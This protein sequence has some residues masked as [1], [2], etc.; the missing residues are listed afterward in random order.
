MPQK[1]TLVF[2]LLF[3]V[4]LQLSLYA[5]QLG[6]TANRQN[7]SEG[8]DI[9]DQLAL[10][11]K[12]QT[13]GVVYASPIADQD[14]IYIGSCDSNLYAL[15]K[16]TGA[17]VWRFRSKGEIR[18]SVAIAA[19]L[20]LFMSTDGVFHAIDAA[21]G[22]ERWSFQTKGERFLIPGIIINLHLRCMTVRCML[23]RGINIFMH[24][25]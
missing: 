18:S 14:F 23:V 24:S 10:Q 3:V 12:F 15:H 16:T 9:G 4:G 2:F 13:K 22:T 17:E 7:N 8:A 21:K 1:S 11:W 25:I 19:G 20:V 6:R 5:Q